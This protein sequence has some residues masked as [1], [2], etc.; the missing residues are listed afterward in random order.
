MEN[1]LNELF[2]ER[3]K[4]FVVNELNFYGSLNCLEYMRIFFLI[5]IIIV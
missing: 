3:K 2:E 4:D 1:Y 5:I